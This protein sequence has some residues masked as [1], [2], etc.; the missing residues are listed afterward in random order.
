MLEKIYIHIFKKEV[1]KERIERI[2]NCELRLAT[3]AGSQSI[4]LLNGGRLSLMP[5][6]IQALKYEGREGGGAISA[7]ADDATRCNYTLC[8]LCRRL[9]CP[10]PPLPQS[11]FRSCRNCLS[12]LSQP[13]SPFLPRIRNHLNFIAIYRA[14]SPCVNHVLRF[15]K[16]LF[17]YSKSYPNISG[18]VILSYYIITIKIT[19]TFEEDCDRGCIKDGGRLEMEG[20]EEKGEEEIV[21]VERVNCFNTVR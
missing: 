11:S 6:I 1:E 12:S 10:T 21:P 14:F 18:K 13:L 4:G 5:Y 20:E 15:V 8:A 17:A 16:L 3:K 7:K 2:W 19:I 9:L